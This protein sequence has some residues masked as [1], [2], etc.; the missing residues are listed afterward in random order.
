MANNNISWGTRNNNEFSYIMV[1][2]V[3]VCGIGFL[4]SI[5]FTVER[6]ITA[7]LILAAIAGI[8]VAVVHYLHERYLDWEAF[9]GPL[10]EKDM[11]SHEELP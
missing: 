8:V 6:V 10:P 2:I 4:T 3:V 7:L 9:Y 1:G 5:F 11:E